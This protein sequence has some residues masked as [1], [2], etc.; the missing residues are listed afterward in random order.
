VTWI[1]LTAA[2]P[3][4][5]TSETFSPR[6]REVL[7]SDGKRV[8]A[9]Y[10]EAYDLECDGSVWDFQWKQPGRDSYDL[11]FK[12]THWQPMPAPPCLSQN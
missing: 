7:V 3:V 12:P 8:D 4:A 10:V 6:S 1:P 5:D 11:T 9:A 2:W